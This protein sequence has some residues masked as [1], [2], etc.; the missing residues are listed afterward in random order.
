MYASKKRIVVDDEYMVSEVRVP[1]TED[2]GQISAVTGIGF[3][4]PNGVWP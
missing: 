1:S 4:G 2:R 3:W